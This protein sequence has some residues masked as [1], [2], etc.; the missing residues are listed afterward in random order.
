MCYEMKVCELI[1]VACLCMDLGLVYEGDGCGSGHMSD[2]STLSVDA[3]RG[4]NLLSPVGD[5]LIVGLNRLTRE[6][7]FRS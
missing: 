4:P 1:Y 6:L 3:F 5:A 7:A 2:E